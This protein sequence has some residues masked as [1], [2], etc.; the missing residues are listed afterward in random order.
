M[1]ALEVFFLLLLFCHGEISDKISTAFEVC[2]LPLA[3]T[4]LLGCDD[5]CCSAATRHLRSSLI[6]KR[7]ATAPSQT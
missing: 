4:A 7:M 5:T 2:L 3:R 6:S 1:P